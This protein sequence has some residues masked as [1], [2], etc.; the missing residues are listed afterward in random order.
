MSD[1]APGTGPSGQPAGQRRFFIGHRGASAP[2]ITRQ[3]ADGQRQPQTQ[4]VPTQGAQQYSQLPTAQ[5]QPQ[6]QQQPPAQ[7]QPQARHSLAPEDALLKRAKAKQLVMDKLAQHNFTQD[8]IYQGKPPVFEVLSQWEELL[9]NCAR[10]RPESE[11]NAAVIFHLPPFPQLRGVIRKAF[12][13]N[14]DKPIEHVLQM[15]VQKL[16]LSGVSLALTTLAGFVL[17]SPEKPLSSYGLASIYD[18]WELCVVEV[19][20]TR[21]ERHR[22]LSG[23]AKLGMPQPKPAAAGNRKS[24]LG[25]SRTMGLL[26]VIFPTLPEF[27]GMRK[28]TIRVDINAQI[29]SIVA[30]ILKKFSIDTAGN[31]FCFTTNYSENAFDASAV[32][33]SIPFSAQAEADAKGAMSRRA[34]VKLKTGFKDFVFA[35]EAHLS[36]YGL[37]VV[38]DRLEVKLAL[39]S[40]TSALKTDGIHVARDFRWVQLREPFVALTGGGQPGA[41][42]SDVANIVLEMD[43][44]IRESFEKMAVLGKTI[45]TMQASADDMRAK[46]NTLVGEHKTALEASEALHAEYERI[47]EAA[48]QVHAA[49]MAQR[50]DLARLTVQNGKLSELVKRQQTR[51]HELEVELGGTRAELA[52]QVQTASALEAEVERLRSGGM[53][54]AEM[55]KSLD[56]SV[57][58]QRADLASLEAQHAA[59]TAEAQREK[60]RL[61]TDLRDSRRATE[62]AHSLG[63]K[64][65]QQLLR[66]RE[67]AS[68]A[69]AAAQA[70][71][72]ES[73]VRLS[74]A[75]ASHVLAVEGLGADL[76][77]SNRK[78]EVLGDRVRD[79]E[80]A[81]VEAEVKADYL[82]FRM[83]SAETMARE[84]QEATDGVKRERDGLVGENRALREQVEE[85]QATEAA[86]V[87]RIVDVER[88]RDEARAEAA[89]QER[90]KEKRSSNSSENE[91]RMSLDLAA[92]R[93]QASDARD[94]CDAAQRE[95]AS[96]ERA[97]ETFSAR[98]KESS[99]ADSAL[100]E[101]NSALEGEC[102]SLREKVQILEREIEQRQSASASASA[103]GDETAIAAA[104]A[105]SLQ[106]RLADALAR[107]D[108]ADRDF[109]AKID[110]AQRDL[111]ASQARAGAL[112]ARADDL[113]A[114]VVRGQRE[115]EDALVKF[116]SAVAQLDREKAGR[117]ADQAELE[118]QKGRARAAGDRIRALETESAKSAQEAAAAEKRLE[119]S[120][121]A[122][123]QE[124]AETQ[125]TLGVKLERL[126]E[127]EELHRPPE[128]PAL[129]DVS[130]TF[131]AGTPSALAFN[132]EMFAAQKAK[133]QKAEIV[134]RASVVSTGPQSVTE[135]LS[136]ALTN[137]FANARQDFEEIEELD[138]D[139]ISDW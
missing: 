48:G 80:A 63:E 43:S 76:Q 119:A 124:L 19:T 106:Q 53:R 29:S 131:A 51:E 113:G 22:S 12:Y 57:A 4:F 50:D 10:L 93:A 16:E 86:L 60:E 21:A 110:L 122:A 15:I 105:E 104:R 84:A 45:Q 33:G 26:T 132:P 139:C 14:P 6:Q 85:S 71:L 20:K 8:D 87:Q 102:R 70:A 109:A 5:A 133:L 92:A 127:L 114:E 96:L 46:Y 138:E 74:E 123:Q 77:D 95:I 3:P 24:F 37:S 112:E 69:E 90:E 79:L 121:A 30:T 59:E 82:A 17:D 9:R 73:H 75:K 61:E 101:A 39:R 1:N 91:R 13:V 31:R 54:L 62:D 108:R 42:A 120:L 103:S 18:H 55:V 66:A 89:R 111:A 83:E 28:K 118:E 49:F 100:K 99:G 78:A 2:V 137:R 130:S 44:H 47:K 81:H 23:F 40:A 97:L 25:A 117:A 135:I 134:D 107:A 126:E 129:P 115:H 128:A 136:F 67:A 125:K 52:S 32:G 36:E 88:Q 72:A 98:A 41:E 11:P 94:R 7:A 34:S 35:S 64:T 38:F 65:A 68:E 27:R 116:D 56:S 58:Q